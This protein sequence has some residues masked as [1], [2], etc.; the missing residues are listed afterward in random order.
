MGIFGERKY[1]TKM[2]GFKSSKFKVEIADTFGKMGKGLMGH[3]PLENNQGMLFVFEREGRHGFWMLNMK[4]SIDIIWLDSNAK[5]VHI[6]HS[7]QP[8]T[9]IFSCP[10]V[11]P[12]SDASYVIELKAGTAS[13][14]GMKRGDAFILG[15]GNKP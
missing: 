3:R 13:R 4:F 12:K 15:L 14:L 1:A 8:C 5:I 10:T 11:R 9:S 2:V 7:A 6:W